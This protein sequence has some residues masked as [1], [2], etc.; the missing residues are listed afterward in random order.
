MSLNTHFLYETMSNVCTST[1]ID[2]SD[3]YRRSAILQSI[4]HTFTSTVLSDI[5]ETNSLS[6]DSSERQQ[7]LEYDPYMVSGAANIHRDALYPARFINKLPF[8]P[9]STQFYPLTNS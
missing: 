7:S 2:R 4:M 6:S 1:K 8:P 9:P 5:P 3:R